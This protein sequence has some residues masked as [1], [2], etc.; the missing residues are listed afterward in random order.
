MPFS[1]ELVSPEEALVGI[2]LM[3]SMTVQ[4]FE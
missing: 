1:V 3:I 4:A 2:C